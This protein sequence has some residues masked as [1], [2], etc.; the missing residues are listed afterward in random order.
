MKIL[1]KA[2]RVLAIMGLSF[3]AAGALASGGQGVAAA[4]S[5][6]LR[7]CD[8]LTCQFAASLTQCD[9]E[10]IPGLKQCTNWSCSV[11]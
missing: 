1:K 7:E 4:E 11:W 9:E 2:L 8:G 3:G 6:C 10:D 5:G